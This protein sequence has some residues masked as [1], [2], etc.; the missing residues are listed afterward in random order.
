LRDMVRRVLEPYTL[1]AGDRLRLSGPDLRLRPR[2]A[3]TLAMVLHELAINAAKYGALATP[4]GRIAIDWTILGENDDP[5]LQ[6]T[7][8]ESGGPPVEPPERKGF[9]SVLIERSIRQELNG[10]AELLFDRS[11]LIC[12]MKVQ[13]AA[14]QGEPGAGDP[15]AAAL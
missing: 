11:G 12:T 3:L 5:Q 8:R 13:L 2:A 7:W 15:K 6:L 4:D 9:G 14:P 10:T 1:K